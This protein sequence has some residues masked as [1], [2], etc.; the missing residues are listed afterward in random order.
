MNQFGTKRVSFHKRFPNSAEIMWHSK[1]WICNRFGKTAGKAAVQ[2]QI[3]IHRVNRGI[4]QHFSTFEYFDVT[5]MEVSQQNCP[6]IRWAG[7]NQHELHYR[8]KLASTKAWAILRI[9]FSKIYP[10]QT[11]LFS[12]GT[13]Q[14]QKT[15]QNNR[16]PENRFF[17]EFFWIF[18]LTGKSDW[19][20]V[21]L[22]A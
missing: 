20:L 11:H 17:R 6:N 18:L 2:G 10:K 12:D 19:A 1:F 9:V 5:Y 3:M 22:L 13:R 7:L 16:F 15:T 14:L 4:K 21:F 8:V